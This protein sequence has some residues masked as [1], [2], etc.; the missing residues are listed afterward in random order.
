M[1]ER[2]DAGPQSRQ[3]YRNQ[4]DRAVNR[5][6]LAEAI[7][8]TRNL[9]DNLMSISSFIQ[10]DQVERRRKNDIPEASQHMGRSGAQPQPQL[11]T[12]RQMVVLRLVAEGLSDKEIALELKISP[13][14]AR[15]HVRAI[16]ERMGVRSRTEAA[17]LAMRSGLL[18]AP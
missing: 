3:I 17:I 15:K 14:T 13:D 6:R 7:K 16:R 8:R 12:E 9:A 11:L 2:I 10:S 5:Q 1:E 4:E 18:Q